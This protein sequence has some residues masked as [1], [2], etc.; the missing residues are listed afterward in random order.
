MQRRYS[1]EKQKSSK[2]SLS[3]LSAGVMSTSFFSA[4]AF[5]FPTYANRCDIVSEEKINEISNVSLPV[6]NISEAEKNTVNIVENV[7]E[8][9]EAKKGFLDNFFDDVCKVVQKICSPFHGIQKHNDLCGLTNLGASCYLN[10]VLQQFY[11]NTAFRNMVLNNKW[12]SQNQPTLYSMQN[13]FRFMKNGNV[14]NRAAMSKF[15]RQTKDLK[16]Y[17]GKQQDS[18]ECYASLFEKVRKEAG[19]IF[20]RANCEYFSVWDVF[21]GKLDLNKKNQK[22][23]LTVEFTNLPNSGSYYNNYKKGNYNVK[24]LIVHSGKDNS[25]YYYAYTN[26]N[27]VWFKLND[28]TVTKVGTYSKVMAEISKSKASVTMVTYQKIS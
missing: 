11:T 5:I 20:N 28:S 13:L 22:K 15:I 25:G 6:E 3:V 19:E 1:H 4:N 14:V 21:E 17:D 26:S 2:K 10:S 16:L 24:T 7:S 8:P 12:N 18:G 9:E 27:G 23:F